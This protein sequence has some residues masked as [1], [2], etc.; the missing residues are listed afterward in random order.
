MSRRTPAARLSAALAV[1]VTLAL[2]AGV[3]LP[4]ATAQRAWA[5][6]HTVSVNDVTGTEGNSGGTDFKFTV[7]L[8]AAATTVVTVD[9]S[10]ANGTATAGS[11]YTAASGTL[12]F[13]PNQTSKTVSVRVTGDTV[14][15]LDETFTLNLANAT[16]TTIADGQGLGTILDDDAP[17]RLSVDNGTPNPVLE[18]DAVPVTFTVTLSARSEKPVT[19]AYATA[20]GTATAGTDY[21]A[22]SGTLTFEPG[23]TSRTVEVTVN[24]DTADE[25]DETFSLTLSSPTNAT[26]TTGRG[27]G[28]ATI[29]D[30]DGPPALSVGDV[31][32]SEDGGTASFTVTLAPA[33]GKTVSVKCATANGTA[34]AGSDYTA[35]NATVTINPGVTTGACAVP[36]LND[37]VDE[38]DE[39]FLV[40]LS[41]ATNAVVADGQATGTITDDDAGSSLSITDVTALEGDGTTAFTFTVTLTPASAQ[42]VTVAYATADGTAVTPGDYVAG[43]GLLT[44]VPGDTAE[45]VTVTV[46]GDDFAEPAETFFV[47]LSV[48]SNA[49]IADG[50]GVGT[51]LND[52]GPPVALSVGDTSVTE[53]DSA[54]VQASFTVSLSAAATQPVT[55]AYTTADG[56]ARTPGDY[57]ARVGTLSFAA[58]E[59]TK[60]VTVPVTADVLDE[61]DETFTLNL[62]AAVNA[63]IADAQGVGTIIDNDAA[64]ALSIADVT[65]GE[66]NEGTT[67]ATFRVTLSPASGRDVTVAYA[68]GGGTATAATDYTAASGTLKFAPGQTTRDVSVAVVGDTVD[69]DDETILL[70]LSGA[71]N[72]TVADAQGTATITDDDG[73]PSLSVNDVTL[74]EGTGAT[75]TATFTV[76]LSPASGR[77][78]TVAYAT[79][80]GTAAAGADYTTTSGT[81]SFP[82]GRTSATFDVTIAGDATDEAAETFLVTLS[83]AVNA[84][85]GDGEGV[86]TIVDDDGAPM[87]SIDDA[88]VTEPDTGTANAV[89]TVRLL[90]ASGQEVTVTYATTAG[91]A[92]A[93]GDFTTTT[94][95][96]TFPA[97]QT[98]G[99]ITVPVVGDTVDEDDETFTV[100]LTAGANATIEDGEAVGTIVDNDVAPTLSVADATVV[101]GNTGTATAT[102]T[103]AL[104][105]ASGRQ[106]TVNHATANGTATA[107]SDYTAASGT[108]TFA[109]G[110]TTRT[111]AVTVTADTVDEDDETFLLNLSGAVNATVADGQGTATITDDDAMPALAVADV[112]VAEGDSTATA[113]FTVTLSAGSGRE[114]TVNYATADGTATAG[115]DYTAASG[116]L[117]LPAGQTS[118]TVEVA[119]TGDTLD[120]D[121]ETFLLN[122][123]A[124]V[125]ATIADAQAVATIIEDDDAASLAVAD[126]TVTEGSTG[127]TNA[128]FTVT[129]TGDASRQV[130]VNVA[131]ADGTATAPADYAATTR[132]VTLAATETSK[133]FTVPVVADTLDEADETFTVTLSGATNAGIG[134]GEATGTIVD[135]DVT[136]SLSINDVS[137]QEAAS[138][139]F[140]VSL[141]APSGRVVSVDYATVAGSAGAADFVSAAGSVS[142]PAGQ[143]TATIT[144]V[145]RGDTQVEGNE[146]FSVNLS[147]PVNATVAKARG[148]ATIVDDD[149]APAAAR[150]GYWLVASDGGIFAFGDARFHGSTGA[151]TL[152][153]PIVGSA[154]TP[155]GNGYWLVASDGGIFAF[156]DA[157]FHG[158]TGAIKLAQPIVGM[159]STPSG[160]G[161]WLVASD[162]GIFAFGDARF[163]GSTGALKLNKP[164]VAMAAL[165]G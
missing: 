82:A 47:D 112:S 52:D 84:T 139:T 59:I 33:S 10:T 67:A 114:V 116:T 48:P 23:Q 12:V 140:T 163:A 81:L 77:D 3:A 1:V 98:E 128:V 91:T 158:S 24:D 141:S 148:V 13:N 96:L 40:N 30:D 2:V 127:T 11:D 51:I 75:T 19:V 159:A 95:T 36:V 146:T 73:P 118:A 85:I 22:A 76:T 45:T 126:V 161:Y 92:G 134:D 97:G 43:T 53:G 72:A 35:V 42:P 89:F 68:T 151:I 38:P 69:E 66:G 154:P 138:A 83:G 17:P 106:V 119:V 107:G 5:S 104:S 46:V 94:G 64:P 70:N 79:G 60:T 29:T 155:S 27:T 142:I 102:F 125:N 137:V 21:T 113:A 58:G 160:D 44:F 133:T 31:T 150:S 110:E 117:T 157:R 86:G 7:S 39:T 165:S 65:V 115:R 15:E 57:E 34:T 103:V 6:S 100:T 93:G 147:R 129:R 149:E 32:V 101:E 9:Y 164:V 109:P 14:D 105:A 37:T 80:G 132:T 49:T 153:Q 131:T 124:A 26:I 130:T 87:V 144:I 143:T 50:R 156:G 4:A 62:S 121:D 54:S 16:G 108:L 78:V 25:A 122:L 41:G 111:V 88:Q 99:T 56:T 136:P 123:S 63:E 152:N 20:N 61:D 28:T 135:D 120:E 90:P 74:E 55:V 8:S 71:V 18:S 162:G 145:G